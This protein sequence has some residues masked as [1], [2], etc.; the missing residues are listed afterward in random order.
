VVVKLEF[1]FGELFPCVGF[2]ATNLETDSRGMVG[3]YSKRGTA[4][5][6]VAAIK[7][8]KQPVKMTR[9]SGH[10]FCSNEVHQRLRLMAYN[11]GIPRGGTTAGAAEED[12]QRVAGELA[13]AARKDGRPIDQARPVLLAVPRGERRRGD[14][15]RLFSALL[16]RGATL[17]RSEGP[18]GWASRK[19][20]QIS[21]TREA[22]EGKSF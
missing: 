7:K 11:Q 2:I 3:P 22:A 14:T 17:S 5:V 16:C 15:R 9:L 6:A 4:E 13:A 18:A 21:S 10:R 8:G 12:R 20:E 19:P 1:H